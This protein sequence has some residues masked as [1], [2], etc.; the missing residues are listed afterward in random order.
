MLQGSL[1]W[2]DEH[3]FIDDEFGEKVSESPGFDQYAHR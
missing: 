1:A 3:C 2:D